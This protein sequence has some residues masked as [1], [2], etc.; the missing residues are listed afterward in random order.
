MLDSAPVTRGILVVTVA[1]FGLQM[2]LN[3]L[4][5]PLFALWPI[6]PSRSGLPPFALWQLASYALLHANLTHL[7]LNMVGLAMFGP[8]IEHGLGG[9]R[10]LG[11]YG[12]SVV[13]AGAAQLATSAAGGLWHPTVG[14]SGGIFGLMLAIG[15]LYPRRVFMLLIPPMPVRAG[16]LAIVYGAIELV[17]GV[18]G[19]SA[20]VAH[21]AHLGGMLGAYLALRGWGYKR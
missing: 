12:A 13:A 19:T 8:Q 6:G 1:V 17:Q 14:A 21:F 3:P 5:V 10:L 7:I 2:L 20:G 11:L 15:L 9:R 4:L 16:T 18:L